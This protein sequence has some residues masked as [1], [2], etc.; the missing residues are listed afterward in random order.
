MRAG[1]RRDGTQAA[2]LEPL[3]RPGA[4]AALARRR[5]AVADALRA[6]WLSRLLVWA[7]GAGAAALWG[8]SARA[9]IFD[10]GAVTRPFGPVGNALAAPLARW[11]SVW[12]L[13]I[14]NDGYPAD[15]ARRAA[16][17]PLYPL[18]LRAANAVVGSPI[19]AGALVSV[20]CFAV[21]LVV[22]QRLAEIELGS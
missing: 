5:P 3:A 16:F 20:G 6:L 21:A 17:F 22:L 2:A 11:D 1:M 19:V 13:A 12:Y 8:L 18:L 14:S 4:R 10:P 15:D 7:V 9:T